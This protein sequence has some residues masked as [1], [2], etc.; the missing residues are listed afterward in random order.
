MCRWIKNSEDCDRRGVGLNA[1]S[2]V[3]SMATERV[4]FLMCRNLSVN[5]V[6][7]TNIRKAPA[8]VGAFGFTSTKNVTGGN[9]SAWEPK[10]AK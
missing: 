6:Y 8:Y 2:P 7:D 4:N 10:R 3:A 9:T 5:D 1:D